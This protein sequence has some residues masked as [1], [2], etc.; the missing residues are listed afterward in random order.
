MYPSPQTNKQTKYRVRIPERIMNYQQHNYVIYIYIFIYIMYIYKYILN[1]SI[2]LLWNLRD[3][4][5][6]FNIQTMNASYK[7]ED[8]FDFKKKKTW[9]LYKDL[10]AHN[11]ERSYIKSPLRISQLT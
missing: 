6:T 5:V 2:L 3:M 7:T 9:P 10:S 1:K 4:A 8:M 11:I